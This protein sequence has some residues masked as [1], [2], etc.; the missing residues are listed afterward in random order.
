MHEQVSSI[1]AA[2]NFSHNIV[3]IRKCDC[4][5]VVADA[6]L[7]GPPQAGLTQ[8]VPGQGDGPALRYSLG[9][10]R[11]LFKIQQKYSH[12]FMNNSRSVCK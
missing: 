9:E 1:G 7:Y 8:A 2:Q 5:P 4:S 10:G 6:L 3:L 12:I 11:K